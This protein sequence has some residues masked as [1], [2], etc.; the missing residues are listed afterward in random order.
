MK[1]QVYGKILIKNNL[2]K[3]LATLGLIVAIALVLKGVF[4]V[5]KIGFKNLSSKTYIKFDR[6][7][8][9]V[10]FKSFN[11]YFLK[12][13]DLEWWISGYWEIDLEKNIVISTGV[14]SDEA[15][16]KLKDKHNVVSE[17]T[18]METFSIISSSNTYV[19]TAFN[20][21][22]F[23]NVDMG[24]EFAHSFNLKEGYIESKQK[25]SLTQKLKNTYIVK[26]EE[27]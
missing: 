25:D 4:G 15:L 5:G 20:K 9:P 3:I 6:C 16:K 19:Q 21:L 26:C 22:K 11:E 23:G 1:F 27:Y 12:E 14:R 24:I 13:G 10:E 17:K 7:Y 18:T 8:D 2:V